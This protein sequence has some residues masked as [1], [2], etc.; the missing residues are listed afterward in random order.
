MLRCLKGAVR[1]FIQSLKIMCNLVYN[2]ELKFTYDIFRPICALIYS[3]IFLL[4]DQLSLIKKTVKTK[5]QVMFE[6]IQHEKLHSSWRRL[7]S[8]HC[9]V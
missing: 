6:S 1:I 8:D 2:E 4:F 7:Y 3:N 5:H 9:D